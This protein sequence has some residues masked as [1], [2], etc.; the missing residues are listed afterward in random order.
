MLSVGPDLLRIVFFTNG[1]WDAVVDPPYK[2]FSVLFSSTNAAWITFGF[3]TLL[4]IPKWT[5]MALLCN[6]ATV[7]HWTHDTV[8]QYMLIAAGNMA[9]IGNERN[10]MNLSFLIKNYFKYLMKGIMNDIVMFC[11]FIVGE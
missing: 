3:W 8:S 5:L 7:K 1:S 10:G 6:K 9:V 2:F 11:L 4:M